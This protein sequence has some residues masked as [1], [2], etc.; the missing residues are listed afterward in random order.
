MR[1]DDDVSSAGQ[2][3]GNSGRGGTGAGGD[4]NAT[5]GGGTDDNGNADDLHFTDAELDAALTD[6]EQ[7]T[8]NDQVPQGASQDG[9]DDAHH[10]FD[11]EL[12]ELIGN[13]AKSAVMVTRLASADLLAAFCQIADIAAQC[14]ASDQGAVAVLKTMNGDAPESAARDL[15]T[16]I[17]GMS[18]VLAVNRADKVE[19]TIYLQGQPGEHIAPPILFASSP[20]FVEDLM[21][22]MSN[23]DDLK[24]TGLHVVDSAGLDH[25]GAMA[26]IAKHTRFGR[27]SSHIQ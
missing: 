17:A 16:V 22:G 1:D 2:V 24:A 18:T 6:F 4:D 13:K 5:G 7:E 15:T 3:P 27:G 23:L 9:T 14:V 20:S 8:H 10:G 19:A 12:Q 25:D 21:L 26:V 11:N